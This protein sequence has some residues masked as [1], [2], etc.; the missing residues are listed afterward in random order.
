MDLNIPI[1]YMLAPKSEDTSKIVDFN[2]VK[3]F[4][5]HS[6]QVIMCKISFFYKL[7]TALRL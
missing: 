7:L 6:D 1:D 3:A 2:V 5:F 4:K